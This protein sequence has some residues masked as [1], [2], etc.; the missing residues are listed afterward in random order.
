MTMIEYRNSFHR[1][2]VCVRVAQRPAA[3]D[4]LCVKLSARQQRRVE[5]ELCGISGCQ[6][7]SQSNYHPSLDDSGWTYGGRIV[8]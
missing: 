6:C 3:C 5:K 8:E 2:A 4:E 7:G 1:T